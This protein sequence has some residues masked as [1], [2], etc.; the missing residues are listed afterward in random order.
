MTTTRRALFGLAAGGLVAVAAAPAAAQIV[1]RERE[2][3]ALRVEVMGAPPHPGWHFVRGHWRWAPGGWVWV[4]GHWIAG[5]APPMPEVVVE[6]PGAAPGPKYFWV[7]GHWV[8]AGNH[9]QW[10]KGH[11]VL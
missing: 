8:W 2:M 10:V 5:E 11:W 9:W 7:R 1:I 6:T 4:P 3:P